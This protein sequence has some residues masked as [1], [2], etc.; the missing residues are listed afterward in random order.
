MLNDR[1]KRVAKLGEGSYGVVWKYIDVN[2]KQPKDKSQEEVKK[3]PNEAPIFQVPN[4][5][6]DK[7]YFVAIKKLK[8]GKVSMECSVA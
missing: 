8:S 4:A 1:Y 7:S 2:P 5:I 6:D 3:P